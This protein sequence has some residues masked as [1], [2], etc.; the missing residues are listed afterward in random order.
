[1]TKILKPSAFLQTF[2]LLISLLISPCASIAEE[3]PARTEQQ[4]L[5]EGLN[6]LTQEIKALRQEMKELRGAVKDMSQK[7]N[8][9]RAAATRPPVKVDVLL[10]DGP[11]LGDETATVGIVEFTDYQC[12]FCKRFHDQ[13]FEKI[14]ETY[15]DTGKIQYRVRDF[16]LDFHQ[17]AKPAALAARCANQQGAY[18][19]MHHELFV[20]QRSLGKNLYS[21]LAKKLE[22]AEEE[23]SNCLNNPEQGKE[24]EASL[25]YGKS[26]GVRGTPN[27]HIGR[28]Q[29]GKLVQATRISGAQPF[30]RFSNVIDALLK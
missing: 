7:V 27:F 16:P 30:T 15:I 29:D 26:I 21:T 11:A 23:F 4:M 14:K 12:P 24:V 10:G 22:L 19:T 8:S 18:W 1:M 5:L 6:Q 28:I 13:T 2:P 9:P 17:E 3:T 20:N 25:N